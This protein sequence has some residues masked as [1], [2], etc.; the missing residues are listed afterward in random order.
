MDSLSPAL[1]RRGRVR[2]GLAG[3]TAPCLQPQPEPQLPGP[4]TQLQEEFPSFCRS[5]RFRNAPG[6]QPCAPRRGCFPVRGS[7]HAAALCC[8][9]RCTPGAGCSDVSRQP[10]PQ[11]PAAGRLDRAFAPGFLPLLSPAQW[12]LHFV[13]LPPRNAVTLRG[14]R[15]PT[16]AAQGASTSCSVGLFTECQAPQWI[17]FSNLFVSLVISKKH[18]AQ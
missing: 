3:S 4:L 16:W 7:R 14:T 2:D 8:S 17:C 18:G 15:A 1:A 12:T 11:P 10:H 5:S 13:R 6:G 9:A